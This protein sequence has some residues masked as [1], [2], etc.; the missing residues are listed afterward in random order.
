MAIILE[1]L[2]Y[3]KVLREVGSGPSEGEVVLFIASACKVGSYRH[4]RA[5]HCEVADSLVVVGV[6]VGSGYYFSGECLGVVPVG[7]YGELK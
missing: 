6:L 5:N 4:I 7:I 1:A 2:L 3:I